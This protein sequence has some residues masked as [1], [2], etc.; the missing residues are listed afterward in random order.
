MASLVQ[1]QQG[2]RQVSS[3]TRSLRYLSSGSSI[4]DRNVTAN[5]LLQH[6]SAKVLTMVQHSSTR[7]SLMTPTKA[8]R[9][10]TNPAGQA[11]PRHSAS[12]WTAVSVSDRSQALS[13]RGHKLIRAIWAPI[14]SAETGFPSHR[15]GKRH[16]SF[17]GRSR[18]TSFSSALR[19]TKT[20][21]VAASGMLD[22]TIFGI[23]IGRNPLRRMTCL[24]FWT[25]ALHDTAG[26]RPSHV[27]TSLRDVV[28]RPIWLFINGTIDPPRIAKHRRMRVEKY[29]VHRADMCAQP[30]AL[31]Y[32]QRWADW[33]TRVR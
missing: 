13:Q 14:C 5:Q 20:R 31:G 33:A 8:C 21:Q 10:Q 30:T 19:P 26:I 24:K 23:M 9:S 11:S 18:R 1:R 7:A 28:I 29:Q 4:S 32:R 3:P 22:G 27:T 2:T 6:A 16:Q 25:V 17:G 15:T 12:R